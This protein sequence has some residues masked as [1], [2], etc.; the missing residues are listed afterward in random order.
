MLERPFVHTT[1]FKQA[2]SIFSNLDYCKTCTSSYCGVSEIEGSNLVRNI[3][4]V[5]FSI[6]TLEISVRVHP[7]MLQANGFY[8]T[9]INL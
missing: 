9:T 8:F 2:I 6:L 7:G 5:L 1:N 3:P 4:N